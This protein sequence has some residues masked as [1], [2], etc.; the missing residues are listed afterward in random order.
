M[1]ATDQPTPPPN[2]LDAEWSAN[3][4]ELRRAA[5]TLMLAERAGHS[6]AA[7]DLAH[8]A[9]LRL[10]GGGALTSM[11]ADEFR[12]RATQVMRHVL[13][14]RARA[15]ATQKRGG[16]LLK[17]PL[18]AFDLAATGG[19]VELLAVD[20]AIEQLAAQ[21]PELGELVRLRFFA[22]L[23]IEETAAALGRSTRT[24]NRD[25]NFAKAALLRLLEE[26]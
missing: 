25:W 4:R 6:L 7:T 12:R 8:E 19:F 3:Y 2:S 1:S 23:S 17:L 5:R 22:G 11:P 9:W 13:I 10:A 21:E 20:E 14:D 15:R 24:V 26:R 18:D 16:R